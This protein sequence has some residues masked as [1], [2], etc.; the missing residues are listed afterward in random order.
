LEATEKYCPLDL[1]IDALEDALCNYANESEGHG[2]P[3]EQILKELDTIIRE[4]IPEAFT[5]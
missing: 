2:R 4:A 1:A 5:S 3:K